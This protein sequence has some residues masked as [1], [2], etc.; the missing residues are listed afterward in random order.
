[1]GAGQTSQAVRVKTDEAGYTYIV[2]AHNKAGWGE[3]SAPSAERRGA[4]RPDAPRTPSIS[5]GDGSITIADNYTLSAEQRNG[6]RASEITYQYR[7]NSGGWQNLTSN[8]IGGLS[9][10]GD[11]RVQIRAL[12]NTGTGSYTGAASASSSV[13]TPFGMPPQPNAT[14]TN[15]GSN[16]TVSWGNNGD[17]G[18]PDGHAD[19][20]TGPERQGAWQSVANSGSQ[21]VR[22]SRTHRRS[23][24]E[25]RVQEGQHVVLCR[26]RFGD[27]GQEAGPAQCG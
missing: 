25:V 16:V 24:I 9:N 3:W 22:V 12:S 10:G 23:S 14:A 19:Q 7:L 2:H 20:G 8:T 17:N 26:L 11:Y 15:N 18:R 6:A 13:V 5:A 1:M 27:D 21:A 4:I